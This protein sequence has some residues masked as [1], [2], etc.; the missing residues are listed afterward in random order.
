MGVLMIQEY[1]G[2]AGPGRWQAAGRTLSP[3]RDELDQTARVA[4]PPP[5][6]G[7]I[8][9]RWLRL[10]AEMAGL[11][12]ANW[13]PAPDPAST[14]PVRLPRVA[15]R[16]LGADVGS[17]RAA[18]DFALATLRRWGTTERSQDIAIVVSELLTNALRHAV[19][20]SAVPGSAVPG[21]A[22]PGSAV[23]GSAVPGSAVP[24]SAVPGSSASRTR[25]PIRFGLLQPG[26]C[27]LCAVADPSR[28]APVLQT[29]GSLAETGRGLHIICALSDQW[30][31]TASDTGKVVWAMFCPRL[32]DRLTRGRPTYL[33]GCAAIRWYRPS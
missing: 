19:P 23:P 13:R 26:S 29:R 25:R 11:T 20:G 28:A 4:Y 30:G 8:G 12:S 27:V 6:E 3:Y 24:G 10:A 18:R 32:T 2:D 9:T 22:V 14:G 16:T 21:S 1:A 17:V 15:M 5:L 31:Y 33:S 7:L